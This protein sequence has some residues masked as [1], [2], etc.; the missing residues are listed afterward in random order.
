MNFQVL[1]KSSLIHL[2]HLWPKYAFLKIAPLRS[3]QDKLLY[4]I[5]FNVNKANMSKII[6]FGPYINFWVI[7]NQLLPHNIHLWAKYAFS[8]FVHQE[9]FSPNIL[10]NPIINIFLTRASLTCKKIWVSV[11]INILESFWPTFQSLL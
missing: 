9:Q 6:N 2:Y 1:C 10:N 4:S 3:K 11:K 7:F 8:K 5:L